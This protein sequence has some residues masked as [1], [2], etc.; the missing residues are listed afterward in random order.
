MIL[1]VFIAY[2]LSVSF[3]NNYETEIYWIEE[4]L[5]NKNSVQELEKYTILRI[6]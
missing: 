4:S 2:F 5:S 1:V 6:A 3:E